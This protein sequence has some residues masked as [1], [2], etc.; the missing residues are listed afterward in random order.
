MERRLKFF[1]KRWKSGSLIPERVSEVDKKSNNTIKWWILLPVCVSPRIE[2]GIKVEEVEANEERKNRLN[3]EWKEVTRW[4]S[5]LAKTLLQPHDER[6]R[7]SIILPLPCVCRV[8]SFP[9]AH[10]KRI[11]NLIS[12]WLPPQV[13]CFKQ[14]FIAERLSCSFS[15]F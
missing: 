14:N 15:Q 10:E 6:W 11:K 12:G 2:K 4:W 1:G 3:W 13:F 5:P 8:V 7:L 9:C